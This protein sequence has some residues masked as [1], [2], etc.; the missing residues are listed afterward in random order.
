[1]MACIRLREEFWWKLHCW[2]Q[3]RYFA[4]DFD[5]DESLYSW[6][7]R[8]LAYLDGLGDSRRYRAQ[9]ERTRRQV[10]D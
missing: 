4:S 7:Q 3:A 9:N 6:Y 1:M 8:S 2:A 5:K 10:Q